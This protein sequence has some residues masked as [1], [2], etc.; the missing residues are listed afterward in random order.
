MILKI[1]KSITIISIL[2]L[3]L[4]IPLDIYQNLKLMRDFRG[5]F[6]R[7][8]TSSNALLM[9]KHLDEIVE[10][11]HLK[12]W[13]RGNT[14]FVLTSPDND[15]YLIYEQLLD[16]RHRLTVI[17]EMDESSFEYQKAL[18][19]VAESLIRW[20]ASFDLGWKFYYGFIINPLYVVFIPLSVICGFV[21]FMNWLDT[22]L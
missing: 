14:V 18:E 4:C 15:L 19:E 8:V 13:H 1:C 21:W 5:Q 11:F 16:F 17:S 7:A 10:T 20:G 22:R 2:V 6:N 9:N 3:F 12:G